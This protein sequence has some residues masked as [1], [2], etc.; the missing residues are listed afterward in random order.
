MNLWEVALLIIS[1]TFMIV[2]TW[3]VILT[4]KL[5]KKYEPIADKSIKVIDKV[6]DKTIEQFEDDEI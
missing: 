4:T 6:I 5:L 2:N 3:N 1:L